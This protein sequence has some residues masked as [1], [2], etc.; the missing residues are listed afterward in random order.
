M[1]ND[2]VP[3]PDRSLVV[4]TSTNRCSVLWVSMYDEPWELESLRR[5]LVM[6][7]PEGPAT[8]LTNRDASQLI[9]RVQAMEEELK[10]LR[11]GVTA[12]LHDTTPVPRVDGSHSFAHSFVLIHERRV[13]IALGKP[14]ITLRHASTLGLAV[15]S[16]PGFRPHLLQ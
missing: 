14:E 10:M 16:D 3:T 8:S 9:S 11:S 5:S 12:L 1:A 6:C 4:S 2:R 15:A 13:H 7:A